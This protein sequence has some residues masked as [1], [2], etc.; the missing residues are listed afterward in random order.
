M[1][2]NGNSIGNEYVWIPVL[3]TH[4]GK[5][6]NGNEHGE[7]NITP[8]HLLSGEGCPKCRYIKS[9]ASKRRSIGD[10]IDAANEVHNGRYDYSL[11]TEYKNKN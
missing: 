5:D 6:E 4:T 2:N 7:F 1:N 11:I 3:Y 9:A 10:V 8:L